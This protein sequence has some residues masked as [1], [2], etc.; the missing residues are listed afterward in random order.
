[1]IDISRQEKTLE[2]TYGKSLSSSQYS[3][4]ILLIGCGGVGS[5]LAEILVRG[6]FS[7]IELIDFDIVDKTNLQRQNFSQKD[8]GES[9]VEALK[10]YLV[11]INPLANIKIHGEKFTSN[12][13]SQNTFS[14][15]FDATDNIETRQEIHTFCLNNSI[16]WIYC[17]AIQT[18]SICYLVKNPE[19]FNFEKLFPQNAKNQGCEDGVLGSSVFITASIAY[20]EFLKYLL[21]EESFSLIKF[22]SMRG[23]YSRV[24]L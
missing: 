7:N 2:N 19:N 20:G 14:I 23:I 9:K 12:Y 24:D 13:F 15:I 11:S 21:G 3:T 6:G 10:S 18:Q 17:G 22:D 8:I 1:M 16:P 4:R 5:I